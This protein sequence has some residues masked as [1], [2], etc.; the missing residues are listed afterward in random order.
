MAKVGAGDTAL[1]TR[2]TLAHQENL[3][4]VLKGPHDKLDIA[5]FETQLASKL[6]KLSPSHRLLLV[7]TFLATLDKPDPAIEAA[8]AAA[9]EE[10]LTR[11]DAAR[12][13]DS[14]SLGWW[15]ELHGLELEKIL[16]TIL[17]QFAAVA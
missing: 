16:Q 9:A 1:N 15:L 13:F 4:V 11:I 12:R 3:V 7:E 14:D 2:E 10:G 5:L 17:A 8:W 6:A